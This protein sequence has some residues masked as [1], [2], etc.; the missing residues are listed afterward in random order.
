MTKTKKPLICLIDDDDTLLKMY[1]LKF[2]IDG[3]K[4]ICAK[5]GT[6]G[7]ALVK[8]Q[9]PD[10]VLLDIVMP[11]QSG[12]QVLKRLKRKEETK[13]IPVILLTNLDSPE[14]RRTGCELGALYFLPKAEYLPKEVSKLVKEILVVVKEKISK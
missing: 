6:E 3:F 5:N 12:F 11:D 13:Q 1:S 2:K 10:I 8:K 4:V 14:D 7:L 9:K